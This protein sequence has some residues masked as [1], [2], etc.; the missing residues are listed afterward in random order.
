MVA[1]ADLLDPGSRAA[2][3]VGTLLHAWIEH[4]GWPAE[5]PSESLLLEVAREYPLL[6]DQH[7]QLLADFRRMVAAGAIA[8]LLASPAAILPAELVATGLPAGPAEP[9]LKRE[10]AFALKDGIGMMQGVIDRLVIW[11]RDGVAVAAE[12]IDFKFDGVGTAPGSAAGDNARLLAEKTLFYTPQL[13][14]YR[15]AVA[16]IYRI[17]Q[18]HV[19]ARLVFMRSGSIVPVGI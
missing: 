19:T 2:R 12:V 13:Q 18:R 16:Q 8:A 1:A 7:Q 10:Q 17:D 9:L 3:E 14:A 5:A 15:A 11:Q 6:A 4:F